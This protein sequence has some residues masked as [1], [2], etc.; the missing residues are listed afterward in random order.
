ML[1]TAVSVNQKNYFLSCQKKN[2]KGEFDIFM[3][4][5]MY[6]GTSFQFLDWIYEHRKMYYL[7]TL[8]NSYI[9][10]ISYQDD[11]YLFCLF[12]HFDYINTVKFTLTVLF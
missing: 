10:Q 1:Y 6:I 11:I 5:Y 4:I 9:L 2:T 3:K 12:F 7:F 8:L